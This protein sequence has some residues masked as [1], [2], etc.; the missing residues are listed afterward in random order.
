M[1]KAIWNAQQPTETSQ[2]VEFLANG[3]I[4]DCERESKALQALKSQMVRLF[5][6]E[7]QQ[8]YWEDA[9]TLSKVVTGAEFCDIV[10]GFSNAIAKDSA[11]GSSVKLG[12]LRCFASCL[13]QKKHEISYNGAKLGVA[14]DGLNKHLTGAGRCGDLDTEYHLVSTIGMLLDAMVDM[15]ITEIDRES[16]H[17]PLRKKLHGLSGSKEPRIA[18]AASYALQ[19]LRRVP[20]NEAPWEAFFRHSGTAIQAI[21]TIGSGVATLNPQKFIEAGPDVLKLL[22]FFTDVAKGGMEIWDTREDLKQIIEAMVD[23]S[24]RR[25]W[26]DAL[27]QT[28]LFIQSGAYNGLKKAMPALNCLNKDMFWCGLYSQ[29]ERQWIS[30]ESSRESIEEFIEWTLDQPYLHKIRSKKQPVKTWIGLIA[31]SV[32]R[33]QWKGVEPT[34]RCCLQCFSRSDK[35]PEIKL[36][37]IPQ[38]NGSE[39]N[40]GSNLLKEAMRHC[41]EAQLFYADATVAQYYMKEQLLVIKRLSGDPVPMESCYINLSLIECQTENEKQGEESR[42]SLSTR[43]QAEGPNLEKAV[44]L[45]DL[46][47]ER[48]LRSGRCERPRR[49]LIRGRAGVGKSTLC[50]KITHAF[51]H[52]DLWASSYD[53][54]IWVPLRKLRNH[55]T[56]ECFLEGAVFKSAPRNDNDVLCRALRET[57]DDPQ[58][59]RTLFIF[60]GLDEI[61]DAQPKPDSSMLIDDLKE[62]LNRKDAIITSR[63]HAIFPSRLDAYDLELET[64]GFSDDQI[65]DYVESFFSDSVQRS[66]VMRFIESHWEFKS[67]LQIPIQLDAFCYTWNEFA[68]REKPLTTMT[69]L[70]QAIEIKLWRKDMVRMSRTVNG[71]LLTE[72]E[73]SK[74]GALGR[75]HKVMGKE[76]ES[77]R[78]LAFFGLHNNIAEFR[79]DARESFDSHNDGFTTL[80]GVSFMRSSDSAL[81]PR[82]QDYY[83]IHLS[84]QEY[85]AAHHF[86]HCWTLGKSLETVD[87]Q[88]GK[89]NIISPAEF[90]SQEKYNGRYHVMW[91]FVAGILA[92][93]GQGHLVR[94]LQ[95]I[96]AKPRDLLGSAHCRIL[97]HCFNEISG[98]DPDDDLRPLR[99]NMEAELSQIFLFESKKLQGH[100]ELIGHEM[101]FPEHILSTLI[102]QGDPYHQHRALRTL[103]LRCHISP[104]V[105]NQVLCFAD[106][107]EPGPKGDA[108]QIVVNNLGFFPDAVVTR[109]LGCPRYIPGFQYHL[110]THRSLPE[111]TLRAA[112]ST[113]KNNNRAAS[114]L[115][116]NQ[117]RLPPSIVDDLASCLTHKDPSYRRLAIESLKGE[118]LSNKA[119]IGDIAARVDDLD[120]D[121]RVASLRTLSHHSDL[122]P[123]ICD[124]IV[125]R[126]L[127]NSVQDKDEMASAMGVL[128]TQDILAPEVIEKMWQM[129][130]CEEKEISERAIKILLKNGSISPDA[131]IKE[132][133]RSQSKDALAINIIRAF[134]SHKLS[135]PEDI[136]HR[137]VSIAQSVSSTAKLAI[138]ALD[139]CQSLPEDLLNSLLHCTDSPRY[140]QILHVIGSQKSLS[141]DIVNHIGTRIKD[142]RDKLMRWHLTGALASQRM[143]PDG[144]LQIIAD[145]ITKNGIL[146]FGAK[147]LY[148]QQWLAPHM[149][150]S[151]MPFVLS[152]SWPERENAIRILKKH[153]DFRTLLPRLGKEYWVAIFQSLAREPLGQGD[154]WIVKGDSLHV[155]SRKRSWSVKIEQPEQRQKLEEALKAVYQDIQ[156]SLGPSWNRLGFGAVEWESFL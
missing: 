41:A 73:A 90:L 48:A 155:V 139:K 40:S 39:T 109:I 54:I 70:Y 122:P 151:V 1:K 135:P 144:V 146:G 149:L 31:D 126:A 5:K 105:L 94:F 148:E 42:F 34:R 43:L 132:L 137:C 106:S 61:I 115:I 51:L 114:T 83:F 55:L 92:G 47:K 19:A 59:T 129:I 119:I 120:D 27:R 107:R 104:E 118:S 66:E 140:H 112:M 21:A 110:A 28:V 67:L 24:A 78:S 44:P 36:K 38:S 63:P 150:E 53:R 68:I 108:E 71:V 25:G 93:E 57:L 3:K 58:N 37:S 88:S 15:E 16:L 127:M 20:D 80:D 102:E 89:V 123:S 23:V 145:N 131:W 136:L 133:N 117:R 81:D 124:L 52:N 18:Q 111:Q 84:F 100:D 77:I 2:L 60:D 10:F 125:P 49:V 32:G 87:L 69:A 82:D 62:I 12:L 96:A 35:K 50:K 98:V 134:F 130:H 154:P 86:V 153:A 113:F 13:R 64:V 152:P 56:F 6:D 22:A 75:I 4:T 128:E 79:W 9:S 99:E 156:N 121:V 7:P 14:L 95:Q 17:E 74:I 30:D 142:E 45:Q 46:F 85:F 101:E 91:R 26:Y 141:E 8:A 76:I 147:I 72:H 29:L 11:N 143:L 97:M 33:P 65:S 138:S 116:G 103:S